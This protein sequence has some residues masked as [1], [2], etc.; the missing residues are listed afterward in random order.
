[1]VLPL[2]PQH[3]FE[4]LLKRDVTKLYLSIAIRNLALGMVLLFEPIYVYLHFG[5]SL[6]IM[7]LFFGVMNGGYGLLAPF[8]GKVMA[9]IGTTKSILVSL[10]LYFGYYLSLF[11][12]PVSGWFVVV[13]LVCG[14]FGMLLFWPA[15]H[16]DFARFSSKG[17]RGGDVGKLNVMRL[18]PM[19]VSP[20]LGGWILAL[21][22]YPVL[23]AVVLAVLLAS[24]IPLLYSRET[25]EV[26]TDSYTQAWRRAWK[27]E[28]IKTSISF[29]ANG[30]EM[31]IVYLFW[32]L[33]LFTLAIT[34][35]SIGVIASFALVISSFFMLYVGKVSDTKERP[36]LLNV[37][38][39]WTSISWTIKYFIATTFD[40]FLA[41]TL[42]RISR[43]AAQVP[44][45]TFYYEKAALKNKETDEFIV[46]Q[47]IILNVT[48]FLV[49]ALIALAF[50]VFPLL[51]INGIFL[52][53]AVLSLG[54]MLAGKIPKLSLK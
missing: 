3:Y 52:I 22:G 1:M 20:L 10:V 51:P 21:F 25:H 28:N 16:T 29:V 6:P 31:T 50:W 39:L 36:W 49:L 43:S 46:N 26:Y 40:A 19:I 2:N 48:R 8:G 30:L 27:K 33:F 23:F 9:A 53:A 42:Y 45:Q 4:Y 7:L 41:H 24:I 17:S 18:L 38:S 15:F 34:F 12:F 11:L 44:F 14:T 5:K 13:A 47:E 35:E 54:F 37:G 32:P